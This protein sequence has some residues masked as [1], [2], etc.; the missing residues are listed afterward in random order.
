[1]H[2]SPSKTLQEVQV[3]QKEASLFLRVPKLAHF[4]FET[5][6]SKIIQTQLDSLLSDSDSDL[7]E[8]AN[9]NTF[10]TA[11]YL[12][13]EDL[14]TN[15]NTQPSLIPL[16]N[17]FPNHTESLVHLS[18]HSQDETTLQNHILL[19]QTLMPVLGRIFVPS[20]TWHLENVYSF[21]TET[22]A[23]VAIPMT[24][25]HDCRTP[26]DFLTEIERA[27]ESGDPSRRVI[28]DKPGV[29]SK[30][31]FWLQVRGFFPRSDDVFAAAR[32]QAGL[33]RQLVSNG[34]IV[35]GPEV[36]G[37]DQGLRTVYVPPSEHVYSRSD[38]GSIRGSLG[39]RSLR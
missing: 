5:E 25:Y 27:L 39:K 14:H 8:N 35:L 1:M 13:E 29:V 24:F 34:Y 11:V 9:L 20:K 21:Q 28:V 6:D 31:A 7:Q 10:P 17:P 16:Q 36:L 12:D 37:A 30:H 32:R 22:M 3:L 38:F 2:P 19:P 15:D 33:L 23:W 26:E 18:V 4:K